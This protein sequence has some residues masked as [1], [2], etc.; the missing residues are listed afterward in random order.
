MDEFEVKQIIK[1]IEY[2]NQMVD[3]NTNE[4]KVGEFYSID[5]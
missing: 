3:L 4:N 5:I 1:S 2:N